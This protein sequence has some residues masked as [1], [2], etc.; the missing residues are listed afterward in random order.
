MERFLHPRFLFLNRWRA[1]NIFNGLIIMSDAFLLLLPIPIPFTNT[2]P[3]LAIV[4]LGAGIMEDDGLVTLFSY[5]VTV[6]AWTF[7]G[8]LFLSGKNGLSLL[9]F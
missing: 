7:F 6:A 1:F 8:I 9:G 3:A 5:L 4:L 2:L